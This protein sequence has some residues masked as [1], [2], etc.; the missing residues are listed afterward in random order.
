MIIA[1][2]TLGLFAGLWPFGDDIETQR[3]RPAAGWTLLVERDRFNGGVSCRAF[4]RGITYESGLLTV[5]F[6][7]RTNTAL[8]E[9]RVGG[10]AVHPAAD[11]VLEAAGLGA[12][13]RSRDLANPSGGR[14][15]LPVRVIGEAE[16]LEVRP[17]PARHAR[18]YSLVGLDA[19]RAEAQAQGCS[20]A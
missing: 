5:D 3:Y 8:A 9:Y 11:H 14:V 10:G 20:D 4:T 13:F 15:Y 12:S 6:G 17:N 18:Q 16:S 2:A 19:V 7:A 1:A